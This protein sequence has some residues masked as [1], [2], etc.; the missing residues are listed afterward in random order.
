MNH[1]L[2]R[3]FFPIRASCHWWYRL[4]LVVCVTSLQACLLGPDYHKP[5]SSVPQNWDTMT[6]QGETTGLLV[7]VES[8]PEVSW[9][10]MF[11]NEEL[12]HLIEQA[13]ERN[14]DLRQAGFRVLEARALAQGAGA[15]LY[16]NLSVNGSYVRV[17]RSETFLVSPTSGTAPGF[18]PPGANFNLWNASLDLRWELDLWGRIRRSQEAFSAEAFA[19]EMNRR[20]IVLSLISEVGQG[21]FRLREFDEQLEIAKHNLALQQ[22][23]LSIIQARA[24]AGLI[25]DL[26][27]KRAEIL[28][29]ETAAQVPEL[30][31]LRSVQQH[32]LELLS[33]VQPNTL[34][35]EVKSLRHVVVQPIIPIGLPADLLQRRPDI[36]EVEENLKAAN[37]RIGEARA[38]FFPTMAL[39]GTGG[40]QTSEFDQ[41]FHWASR[42]LSVGPSVSLPIFE[43]YTNVARLE[44]AETRYHQMLEQYKHTILNAFREVADVLS[45]LQTRQ[46]QLVHQHRQVQASQDARELAEIRYRQGLVTYLDVLDAQRVVLSAELNLV[47]TQR[48]RLTDMVTL[49]KAVGGGWEQEPI[50]I[51]PSSTPVAL[52][53]GQRP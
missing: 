18:A 10:Q 51:M 36:L 14:H 28:V 29:S 30:R 45:A 11:E 27:V 43:G 4:T 44:V 25:S 49:F 37:A 1:W 32:Q 34:A 33:G 8:V 20:A 26:D 31:R 17:R 39:T 16:P 47:K 19:S 2:V 50:P 42:N 15:G 7:T 46:E 41:W 35:L 23:S 22:D 21:Y 12:N 6:M 40:F 24:D 52:F 48:A 53:G 3:E 13:L 9:W 5:D 38:H